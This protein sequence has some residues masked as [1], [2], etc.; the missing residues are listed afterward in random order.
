M[1]GNDDVRPEGTRP[2]RLLRTVVA[3]AVAGTFAVGLGVVTTPASSQMQSAAP[4][5]AGE[6]ADWTF[7]IYGVLDTDNVADVLTRNLASL[8]TIPD[9][10]NVNIVALV[11]MPERTE[12]GYPSQPL[13]GM[14]HFTTAKLLVLEGGRW[15]EIRDLGEISMG[16]PDVLASFIDEVADRYPAEKYGMTLM[17]HGAGRH[18]G[19]QDIG[20]PGPRLLRIPDMRNGLLSGLQQAGIDRFDVL[21]HASCLMSNYETVSALAGTAETMAGSEEL[22]FANPLVAGA[23]APLA[24]NADGDAIGRSLIEGYGVFLEELSKQPGAESLRDLAAMSVVN[25]DQM[26]RL[27]AAMESFSRVAVANMNTIAPEVARA[28]GA[29]LEF[30]VGIPG[31]E[32]S[33]DLVDLGDFLRNLQNVPDEVTVARDAVFAALDGAVTHQLLGRAT[34]QA[35]GLNVYLPTSTD[36]VGDYFAPGVAPAG[37]SSFVRAFLEA[38]SGAGGADAGGVQFVSDEATVLQS[39]ASGIKI[40]G[41]LESGDAA[42]VVDSWSQVFTRLGGHENAMAIQLPAYLNAGGEGAVQ[43]VWDHSVTSLTDG[44]RTIPVTSSYQAQSGGLV[45]SF[46]AQYVSPEGDTLDIGVRLLLSSQGEIQS[47]SVVDVTTGNAANG[48]DLVVGG[49]LTP[50]IFVPTSNSYGKVLSTQSIAVS[51]ELAVGFTKLPATTSFDMGVVVQDTAGST[52]GAFVT[53]QVP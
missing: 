16:R 32:T 13:P 12:G 19:Y 31:E 2:R 53:S 6:K 17:D 22:M 38:S 40:S 24:E 10:T 23:L 37:W 26:T 46:L 14:D 8:T 21:F 4:A 44:Q 1:T 33:W 45:G 15:N 29:A 51:N 34:E 20:A 9:A 42:N 50:Y 41:Q 25:G 7:M 30:V 39:D 43:A 11:D 52:A 28:R 35:T 5:A 18:G 48:V 3:G 27:D 47:V 49:T 36:Y